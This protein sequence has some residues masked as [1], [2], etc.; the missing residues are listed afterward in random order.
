MNAT[1]VKEFTQRGVD[2]QHAATA[3]FHDRDAIRQIE[4]AYLATEQGKKDPGIACACIDVPDLRRV[5]LS[6]G[7]ALVN[8]VT[9][10]AEQCQMILAA[11]KGR[12]K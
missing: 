6:R 1:E 11:L 7:E 10:T 9:A 8:G 5:V 3:R 4:Q 12:A 2:A